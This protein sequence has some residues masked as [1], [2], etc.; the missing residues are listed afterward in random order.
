MRGDYRLIQN[1]RCRNELY[2]LAADPQERI[3][4]AVEQLAL[5]E[6]LAE[7]SMNF[8]RSTQK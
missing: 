7:V 2:D 4:L 6:E 3:N 1:Q 5:V 8:A